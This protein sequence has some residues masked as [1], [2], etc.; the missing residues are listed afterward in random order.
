MK[1]NNNGAKS[2]SGRGAVDAATGFLARSLQQIATLILTFLAAAVFPPVDYAV[3]TLG[4]V[5]MALIQ[6]IGTTGFFHFIVTDSRDEGEVASTCF[7]LM[8]GLSLSAATLLALASGGIARAFDEPRLMPMILA[9][10][11]TQPLA[12][13]TNWGT[14]VLMRRD[15]LRTH[16]RVLILQSAVGLV[17]GLVLILW[18]R[19]I[20]ALLAFTYVRIAVGLI[21]YPIVLGGGPRLVFST[22]VARAAARYSGGLYGTS[23]MTFLS[24]YAADILLGLTFST[25]EAGLY[26]FG[27]RLAMVA[28]E[29]IGQPMRSFTLTRLGAENRDGNPLVG[30]TAGFMAAQTVLTGIVTAGLLVFLSDAI[31]IFFQPAYAASLGVAVA[32]AIRAFLAGPHNLVQPVLA[33]KAQTVASLRH[34]TL[35]TVL[36]IAAIVALAPMGMVPMA[37]AQAGVALAASATGLMLIDRRAGVTMARVLHP[38]GRALTIIAGFAVLVLALKLSVYAAFGETLPS[39]A[40]ALTLSLM[41]SLATLALGVRMGVLRLGLFTSR[42]AS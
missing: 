16:F 33:A 31:E 15:R 11:A 5:F 32:L 29:V 14:A 20:Y 9:L 17:A 27:N 7:W 8:L 23:V 13:V 30:P 2:G 39:F 25:A 22:V 4:V 40:M 38:V 6:I 37:W 18:T 26:R 34:Y 24:N 3:F 41:L 42:S 1:R 28:I 35:W 19:S 10:A 12:V 36:Q 21:A